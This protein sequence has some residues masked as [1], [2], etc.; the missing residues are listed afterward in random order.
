MIRTRG[1][2]IFSFFNAIFMIF[3]M[4]IMVIP[5]WNVLMSSFSSAGDIMSSNGLIL[6][7]KH[8]SVAAY[9]MVAQR[10]DVYSGYLVTILTVVFGVIISLI[11][12]AFGAYALT[13]KNVMLNKYVTGLIIITM[14]VNGGTIPFYLIVTNVLHLDNTLLA[15]FLP[16]A[17]NTWNLM[18]MRSS[19]ASIPDGLVEAAYI[20]GANDF[21]ILFK[22]VI[23]VSMSTVAVM[24]LFYGVSYWNSWFNAMLFIRDRSLYP[25]QLV[26]REILIN[27]TTTDML[28]SVDMA[29]EAAVSESIR[30][31]LIV[32]A[33]FPILCLYP[34]LQKYFIKGVMIGSVKG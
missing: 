12:T 31:A 33:T 23:P 32:V 9:K 10:A 21:T 22:I 7:P 26:L 4:L 13:R 17:I 11:L 19:F 18:V 16:M 34:F 24:I 29:D 6:W 15:L 1:E 5:V 30:Y 25:L 3:L 20:D 28:S 8:F 14:F 2:K 27:N